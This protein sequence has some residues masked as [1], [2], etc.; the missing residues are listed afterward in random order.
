MNRTAIAVTGLLSTLF[1][2][3]AAFAQP[4]QPAAFEGAIG[5]AAF[6]DESPDHHFVTGAGARVYVTPLLSVGP[7]LTYMVGPGSDRDLFATVNLTLDFVGLQASG[8][9]R[10]AVP[11]MVAGV[12]AMR[13]SNQFGDRKFTH[14]EPAFTL[15]FGLRIAAGDRW[16]FAPEARIGWEAHSRL[17]VTVGWRL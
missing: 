12:G 14:T 13:H 15:G 17:G 5:H 11:Y 7:E 3:P 9:P 8:S 4:P 2:A 6:L 10:K 1:G 16:F